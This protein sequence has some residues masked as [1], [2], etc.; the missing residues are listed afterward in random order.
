[1]HS[2]LTGMETPGLGWGSGKGQGEE[3]RDAQSIEEERKEY[4][5]RGSEVPHT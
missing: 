4:L 1:M 5:E 2:G 3:G